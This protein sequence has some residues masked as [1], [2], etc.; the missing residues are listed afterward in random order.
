M[1][2]YRKR[3][4]KIPPKILI[5]EVLQ[6]E[7]DQ[8]NHQLELE[9]QQYE[10]EF[11]QISFRIFFPSNFIY[12]P[13]TKILTFCDPS[14]SGKTITIDRRKKVSELCEQL[15]L[16]QSGF[17]FNFMTYLI[18]LLEKRFRYPKN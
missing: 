18:F 1:L 5:P 15:K 16:L 12:S 14:E 2:I 9:R 13:E 11:N 17:Y 7:I 6:K 4:A 3:N 10:L 8:L